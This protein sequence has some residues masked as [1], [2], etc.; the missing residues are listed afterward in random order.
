MIISVMTLKLLSLMLVTWSAVSIS[1]FMTC[2]L[3][4]FHQQL[5]VSGERS[6]HLIITI[7]VIITNII[8]NITVIVTKFT[9][10][11]SGFIISV[12][13]VSSAS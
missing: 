13:Y 3:F 7:N 4:V 1:V 6:T 10:S 2:S 12:D 9:F 11:I 5:K 8:I